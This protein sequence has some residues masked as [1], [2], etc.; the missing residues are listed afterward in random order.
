MAAPQ[1]GAAILF[2][3]RSD[4][5]QAM[6]ETL[7]R[8]MPASLHRALMPLAHRLRRIWWRW[9]GKPIVGTAVILT[10]PAGE[11]L[12]LRHSYGHPVWAL[13]GGG[14]GR[15]EDPEQGARR[16]LREELG[17]RAATMR[18]V[19]VVEEQVAGIEHVG[20]VFA[21][22]SSETP[23]PD[24]REVTQARFFAPDALP[25]LGQLARSRLALWQE[26][27]CH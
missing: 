17:I 10:N 23:T 6:V 2:C 15:R 19:G 18:A 1:T 25:K 3:S 5:A 26:T 4:M 14:L 12:L 22:L 13:P 24:G 8:L 9:H 21:A 16:E 7:V 11:I 20:H 27:H